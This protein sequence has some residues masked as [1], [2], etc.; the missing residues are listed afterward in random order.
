MPRVTIGTAAAAAVAALLALAG[1]GGDS[2]TGRGVPAST[3]TAT[4]DT[5]V[6]EPGRPGET[7]TVI[8]PGEDIEIVEGGYNETDV[9]F[10]EQ[11]IPHH[12]QALAMAE[13]AQERAQDERVI[14]VADRIA[15]GQGPEITALEAWLTDRDLPVP[16][17]D[18]EH[19]HGLPGMITPLQLEQ[20]G[21]TEGAEFDELFLTYMSQHHAGAIEMADAA[22]TGGMDQPALELATDVSVTQGIEID[23]M[24]ELLDSL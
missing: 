13:L 18:T 7:A 17:A 11:M 24:S 14:L 22:L 19:D 8:E 16:P 3:T 15:A 4:S 12:R 5:R 9:R 2:G 23:R 21:N 20:L 10:V 6:I 1:C